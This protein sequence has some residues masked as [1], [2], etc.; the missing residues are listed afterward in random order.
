MPRSFLIFL[1]SL[2]PIKS[3]LKF[4]Y[5]LLLVSIKI[6][7]GNIIVLLK[8]LLVEILVMLCCRINIFTLRGD[9]KCQNYYNNLPNCLPTTPAN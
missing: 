8:N 5:N 3:R 1:G 9:T 4:A 7:S 6:F 2:G